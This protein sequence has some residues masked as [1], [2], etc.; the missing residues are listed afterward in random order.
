MR[1]LVM[2]IA[3]VVTVVVPATVGLAG[4][5]SAAAPQAMHQVITFDASQGE[6]APG[7]IEASGAVS[8][9]GTNYTTSSRNTGRANHAT[10]LQVFDDGTINIKDSAANESDSFDP[11]TCTDTVTGGGQFKVTGGTGAYAGIS[12]HGHFTESGHIVFPQT[13]DGCDFN[14]PPT[15]TITVTVDGFVRR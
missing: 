6:G 8:G 7:S 14:T 1:R 12:G 4:T 3:G 9:E 13:S 10:E 15:G 11:V 5:A 2:S